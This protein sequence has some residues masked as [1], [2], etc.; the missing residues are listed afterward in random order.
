MVEAPAMSAPVELSTLRPGQIGG[1]VVDPSL[2][3]VSGAQIE[4]VDPA[5]SATVRAFTDKYGRWT[6]SSVPSGKVKIVA[7]APGFRTAVR[8]ID[9]DG[10]RPAR[11]SIRLDIGSTNQSMEVTSNAEVLRDSRR[12]EREAS[13][14]A[15]AAAN[16][17]S[18]NVVNLQ[19]R[20]AG[21][22]PVAVQVPRAGTS[23][24]FVR[25]LVIDEETKV[26]FSYRSK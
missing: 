23:Y 25:P 10:A 22:L 5:T 19:Q 21:V 26:T 7:Q 16:A 11:L 15:A 8:E 1:Y 2:A 24:R 4:V 13:K 20:V 18:A 6:V 9:Y 12:I 14:V 3:V 17:P